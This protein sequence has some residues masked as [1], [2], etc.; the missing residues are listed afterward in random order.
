M[1]SGALADIPTTDSKAVV[2]YVQSVG[3]GNSDVFMTKD[4]SHAGSCISYNGNCNMNGENLLGR[5]FC[6]PGWAGEHCE[7]E[8]T[9]VPCT[10]KDDK[11]FFSPEA[12]VFAIR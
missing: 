9:K 5:C 6:M 8:T 12:G 7:T 11:C 2:D 4:Q 10:H 3:W 1:K